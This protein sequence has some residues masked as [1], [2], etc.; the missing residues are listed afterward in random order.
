MLGQELV[1]IFSSSP[2]RGE[3][4]SLRD[5]GVGAPAVQEEVSSLARP[6]VTRTTGRDGGVGAPA[7]QETYSVTAWDRE[8]VDVTDEKMLR[9]KI[10]DLW[11][12]VIIN[13]TAYNAVDLCETNEEERI[14]AET[15]NIKV[16]GL[17]ADIANDLRSTIV[18]YSTDY[19]FDGER[20]KFREAGRRA[21]GCCG[22]GCASCSYLS[23]E[24]KF[25]GYREYDLPNPLSVYG[26]TKYEGEFAVEKKCQDHYI[27][28]LSKLFGKP[29]QAEGAKRSFFDVMLEK[30]QGNTND[31]NVHANDT[32]SDTNK[33]GSHT[34]ATNG[35]NAN[36]NA[37]KVVDGELSCFT[38]APDLAMKTREL[39][40]TSPSGIYHCANTGPV[41]WYEAT[42]KLFAIAGVNA[43][44]EPVSPD[45]F[46]RPAKRPAKS[47]LIS[48][49]TEPMRS[50][51]DAVRDY[52]KM[53]V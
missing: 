27:I 6:V 52:L 19:V 36:K 5:G 13:A 37:I 39:L 31:T 14:K 9:Q 2:A 32:N 50:W 17:L 22:S 15:L 11:P 21:P 40:E 1:N 49:K 46:P 26:K 4:S 38:Y 20:P 51:E 12:D 42:K 34:N 43:E 44:I 8:D 10:T 18:H 23:K 29:A 28:R 30:A 3:V 33:T 24:K 41:T 53:S 16:P 25:D 35:E 45:A 7:T 47:V 48:T